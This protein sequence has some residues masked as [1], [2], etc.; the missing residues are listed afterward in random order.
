MDTLTN[1]LATIRSRI[2]LLRNAMQ[3]QQVD[4]YIVPSADPHLSEYLPGRWK[5][6]QWLSGFNGSV[7]TL[8]VTAD[9]A[10]LW[11]YSRYWS[12]AK[13]ELAGTG[14]VLM[15]I[16]AANIPQHIDWLAANMKAGQTVAADGAVLGLAGARLLQQALAAADV[17]LRTDADLLTEI[18][19]ER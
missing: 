11:A 3:R 8:I 2:Q 10:G 5:G 1:H 7:G 6:R 14:I 16:A 4:A 13:A 18:W 9:F 12:Q 15:K 19:P 17:N